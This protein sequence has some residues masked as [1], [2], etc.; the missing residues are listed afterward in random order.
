MHVLPFFIE[1]ML[2]ACL[3]RSALGDVAKLKLRFSKGFTCCC[4]YVISCFNMLKY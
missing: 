1:N 3:P 2:L 4:F